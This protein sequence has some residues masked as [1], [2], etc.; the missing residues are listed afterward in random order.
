MKQ[1]QLDVI[2]PWFLKIKAESSKMQIIWRE[3]GLFGKSPAPITEAEVQA[4]VGWLSGEIL[5]REQTTEVLSSHE[6]YDSKSWG[7]FEH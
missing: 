7:E 1:Y 3:K 4:E 5:E 6:F 2:G